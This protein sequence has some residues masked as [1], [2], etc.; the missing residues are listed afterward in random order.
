MRRAD[1]AR[2]ANAPKAAKPDA[3]LPRGHHAIPPEAVERHQRDRIVSA[4]A[5]LMSR[6]G[7]PSLTVGRIIGLARVSRTTFYAHFPN[8]QEAVIGSQE[9]IFDEF[10]AAL[11]S[12]CGEEADWSQKVTAALG[13]T[14][15]FAEERPEQ[16]WIISSALVGS[17]LGHARRIS[18]SHGRL[19]SL[20]GGMRGHS[21]YGAQLPDCTEQFLVGAI[22]ALVGVS[23]RHAI[24]G[25]AEPLRSLRAD[26]IEMTLI[27][28][29]GVDEAV[30]L[31][32]RPS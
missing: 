1:V 4:V 30:R 28:Y 17:D 24:E 31:A 16:V 20:L 13:A 26:L 32:G 25:D 21:P 6:H 15:E 5:T 2:K 3:P 7:Y 29:I 18:D 14:V 27:P 19:A 9:Q 10:Q 8:K 23:A 22:V 11:T 12:A